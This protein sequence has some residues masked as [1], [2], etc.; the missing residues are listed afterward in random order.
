MSVFAHGSVLTQIRLAKR[1]KHIVVVINVNENASRPTSMGFQVAPL[2]VVS[3][4]FL[5]AV[6]Y[7][8]N[9]GN[10]EPGL[11]HFAVSFR[12]KDKQPS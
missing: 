5:G 10:L 7:L 6:F 1:P 9:F 3:D 8:G 11:I 12:K 4:G 2:N